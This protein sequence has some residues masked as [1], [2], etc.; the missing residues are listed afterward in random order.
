MVQM[1]N[2]V[3]CVRKGSNAEWMLKKW[4]GLF[5]VPYGRDQLCLLVNT[6]TD[7]GVS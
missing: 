7:L 2:A 1:R 6:V 4:G 5:D 3:R